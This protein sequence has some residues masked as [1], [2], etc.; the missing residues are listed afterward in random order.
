MDTLLYDDS[1]LNLPIV[2]RLLLME[3]LM[4]GALK[5]IVL[6]V[7]SFLLGLVAF[8]IGDTD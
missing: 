7:D 6:L 4:F 2:H 8:I 5:K 1:M 3:G